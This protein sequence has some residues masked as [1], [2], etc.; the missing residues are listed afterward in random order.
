M[1]V[2]ILDIQAQGRR[3]AASQGHQAMRQRGDAMV[4]APMLDAAAPVKRGPP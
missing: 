4:P 2:D 1:K 3:Q